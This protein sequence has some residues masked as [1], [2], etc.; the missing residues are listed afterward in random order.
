MP[1]GRYRHHSDRL[2]NTPSVERAGK[3]ACDACGQSLDVFHDK[4]KCSE[5]WLA[6]LDAEGN[7][8]NRRQ[9]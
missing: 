9:K 5:M 1:F 3:G 7:P 2:K 6:K 4:K 8:S